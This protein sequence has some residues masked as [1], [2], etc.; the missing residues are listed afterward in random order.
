MAAV[1]I[2]VVVVC[3]CMCVDRL[4]QVIIDFLDTVQLGCSLV[5]KKYRHQI[6]NCTKLAAAAGRHP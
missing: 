1:A 4:W 2:R 6:V 3:V 5:C